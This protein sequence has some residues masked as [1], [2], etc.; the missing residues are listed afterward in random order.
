MELLCH[1]Q[2]DEGSQ[3]AALLVLSCS[4]GQ[5]VHA[6]GGVVVVVFVVVIKTVTITTLT[7][8]TITTTGPR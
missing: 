7:I 6:A 8:T 4:H 2:L 1:P 3:P 5:A